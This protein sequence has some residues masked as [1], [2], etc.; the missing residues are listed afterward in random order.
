MNILYS[1]T[2]LP[3]NNIFSPAHGCQCCYLQQITGVGILI[4][5][6]YV[7]FLNFMLPNTCIIFSPGSGLKGSMW[8]KQF[9][10]V[11]ALPCWLLG[12]ANINC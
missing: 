7:V 3:F 2:Y 9:T 10:N 11:A 5:I 4:Y 1:E 6:V 8:L 12:A